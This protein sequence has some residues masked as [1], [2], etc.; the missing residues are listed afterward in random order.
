VPSRGGLPS[1]GVASLNRRLISGTPPASD[2]APHAGSAKCHSGQTK[3]RSR[4]TIRALVFRRGVL[5][6]KPVPGRRLSYAARRPAKAGDPEGD[7]YHA[8]AAYK[9]RVLKGDPEINRRQGDRHYSA[10][11]VVDE[12]LKRVFAQRPERRGTGH[13]DKRENRSSSGMIEMTEGQRPGVPSFQK[14]CP[15]P[16]RLRAKMIFLRNFGV[17]DKHNHPAP[18]LV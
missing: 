13:T 12:W 17:R 1:G 3:C 5:S 7:Y 16:P 15:R 10:T 2:R 18:L 8:E 6:R 11:P 4:E 14:S 9:A